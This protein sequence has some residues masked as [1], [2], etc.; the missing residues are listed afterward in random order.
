V[1][2]LLEEALN[3]RARPAQL[4]Y[5]LPR[6]LRKVGTQAA[7]NAL[8]FSNPRDDAFLHYRVGVALS[9][10]REDHPELPVD[11]VRVREAL[12]RRRAVYDRWVGPYRDA[13]AALGDEALLTRA[14]GDRLDQALELSFWLLGLL[15]GALQLRRVHG[16]LLG[17]DAR[18][19]AWALELLE[20][21]VPDE[22][23]ER[24]REQVDAHHRV[25]PPGAA[26][27]MAEHVELLC[28][29]EDDVVRACARH[30]A[31][32][33]GLWPA[34]PSGDDMPNETLARLLALEGVEI[35][36]QCDVDDLAAVAAVAREH[37]FGAGERIWAE[38]DPGDA[39][40]IVVKGKVAARRSGDTI[41]VVQEKQ[42]IGD[43]SLLDGS[44]RPT[45]MV[46]TEET[47]ALRV[48]RRD[49]L[50]LLSDRPELLKG[51]F[52]AVSQQLKQVVVE[53]SDA[54]TGEVQ[55]PDEA[56]VG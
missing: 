55:V 44:P 31:R 27:R 34:G 46:A 51:I 30:W 2:P 11:E 48:D 43:V 26:G 56:D 17:K 9:R 40:Y 41:L 22:D 36:A 50:D 54:R 45:D 15:H 13:R 53:L 23:R 10:L 1:V 47:L 14:L 24:V 25:L 7:F 29:S 42:A 3:D 52:R 37:R 20:N 35:F 21:L 49:F 39:L 5:E 38:G 32:G 4:R 6:V 18:R 19:R 28:T 33:L 12:A 16:H 8:L